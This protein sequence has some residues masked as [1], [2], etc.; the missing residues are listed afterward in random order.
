MSLWPEARRVTPQRLTLG[1]RS[2]SRA[3][4]GMMS[5]HLSP[6]DMR[7]VRYAKPIGRCRVLSLARAIGGK[8]DTHWQRSIGGLPTS[9]RPGIG[10]PSMRCARSMTRSILKTW[11]CGAWRPCGAGKWPIWVLGALSRSCTR[12]QRNTGPR[13]ITL[14]VSFPPPNAAMCADTCTMPSPCVIV[15]G[16]VRCATRPITGTGMRPTISIR[17]GRPPVNEVAVR[18]GFGRPPPEF[19]IPRGLPVGVR[20][21]AL[22]RFVRLSLTKKCMFSASE[23]Q[24]PY[25][26]QRFWAWTQSTQAVSVIV[27][28]AA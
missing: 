6:S 15:Y 3:T 12:P 27:Q 10:T 19:R 2:F 8:P 5:R 18:P 26:W 4:T 20:Q 22:D 7:C 1:W 9:A 14:T 25:I 13:S 28:P 16:P 11:S 23:A 21:K 17:R 24:L